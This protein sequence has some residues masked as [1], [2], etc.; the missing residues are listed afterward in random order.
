M[1]V[2]DKVRF[3][4]SVGGGVIKKLLDKDSVL[5]EDETGFDFPMLKK[6]CVVIESSKEVQVHS[7]HATFSSSLVQEEKE[8]EPIEIIETK[9]GETISLYLAYLANDIKNISATTY[10]CFLINESNYFIAYSYLGKTLG[11]WKCR[12]TGIIEPNTQT[13]IEEFDKTDF[14][15]I[16]TIVVQGL[17]YKL[18]KEFTRQEPINKEIK[19]NTT[20]FYKFHCFKPNDFFDEGAIIYDIIVDG[21]SETLF[22]APIDE[23]SEKLMTKKIKDELNKKAYLPKTQSKNS[24]IEV[25][26]HASALLE[27]TVG[28]S[29]SD[30]LNYQLKVFN[31]TIQHYIKNKGTKIVFIHGKGEGVLKQAIMDEIRK[32]YKKMHYQDASFQE[33]GF[34]ATQI[35]IN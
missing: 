27:T 30:I 20:K 5:V 24:I 19:V 32:K 11:R 4:T 34:G 7:Q 1:K 13:F 14:V 12:Q 2:G 35:T 3:L 15:D 23:L 31:D 10:E 26:L 28:M 29:N 8:E 6:E 21:K 25:D 17:A 22:E 33:Y 18:D 9:D 16:E